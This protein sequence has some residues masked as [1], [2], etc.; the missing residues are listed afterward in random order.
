MSHKA[1]TN[2]LPSVCIMFLFLIQP[3]ALC[4]W[5]DEPCWYRGN[6]HAHSTMSDGNVPPEEAVQWYHDHGYN[7]L[8]LTDH[9]KLVDPEN[10]KL[11]AHARQDF[12]LIPGEE[13]SASVHATALNITH[14]VSLTAKGTK[15]E[16]IEKYIQATHAAG[17]L[18]IVN[19]PN[20]QWA[21]T[22]RDL[23][24]A[25]HVNMF[26]VYNGHPA[27]HN[28]GDS[29]HPSTESIWDELLTAGILTYGVASDDAHDY[30][31]FSPRRAN[32]G[33][34]WIMVLADELTPRAIQKALTHGNFYASNGV[35]FKKLRRSGQT[36]EIE[37]D[38]EKSEAEILKGFT[39]GRP[40]E[41]QPSQG[42]LRI[43]FIGPEGKILT[44]LETE[45]TTYTCDKKINYI[46]ARAV[47]S[48]N[49]KGT[50]TEF[51]A[52]TQPLCGSGQ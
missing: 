1:I 2:L 32:P 39:Q 11:P 43:D 41:S 30:K 19:H 31:K 15:P 27:V 6:T 49:V 29:H 50:L 12:I 21:L 44:S 37:V 14:A 5:A 23:R 25:K 36:L 20:Y 4:V 8:S 18:C 48:R 42:G 47:L 16:I 34:G 38:R 40:A 7:F 3:L 9:N 52:W 45:K 35:F 33:R 28:E 46:R 22:G 26:E 10:I 51:C 13:I 17:G 24:K